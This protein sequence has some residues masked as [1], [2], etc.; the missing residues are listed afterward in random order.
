MGLAVHSGMVRRAWNARSHPT[1]SAPVIAHMTNPV[2]ANFGATGPALL[3]V[4]DRIVVINL[5]ER[6]DRRAE[7][8]AQLR[9]IGLSLDHPSVTIFNGIRPSE[10]AGFPNIGTRGC[11]LSHLGVLKL[12]RDENWNA[13]LV[14]ED[15]LNFAR[16]VNALIPG[17]A[18]ELSSRDWGMV[19]GFRP[20]ELTAI[21]RSGP[22]LV[23]VPASDS[24]ICLHIV[25]FQREAILRAIPYLEAIL[26]RPAGSPDGG[27]MHV[28]GAYNWFRA[29]YPQFSTFVTR[30]SLGFQRSSRTDIQLQGWPD[31]IPGVEP[32]VRRLRQIKNRFA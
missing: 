31:R 15:D 7:I 24:I 26:E 27:P 16:N 2:R 29:A 18:A 3:S 25:A 4:F 8:D 28:D 21:P 13:V 14:L 9:R 5:P 19:Y 32:L 10:A 1:M 12:A 6:A 20:P 30:E 22:L 23:E 17:L 11:F